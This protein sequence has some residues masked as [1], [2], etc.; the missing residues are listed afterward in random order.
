LSAARLLAT[1]LVALAVAL[2]TPAVRADDA[3]AKAPPAASKTPAPGAKTAPADAKPAP[4]KKPAAKKKPKL[5]FFG[6]R[7][8]ADVDQKSAKA[9]SDYILS[10]L[11]NAGVYRVL[12]PDDVKA[13]LSLQAQQQLLGCHDDSAC[14]AQIAGSLGADRLLEGSL[15]R[16][17]SSILVSLTLLDAT[18]SKAL[19]RPSWRIHTSGTLEPVLD[20]VPAMITKLV[21]SDPALKAARTQATKTADAGEPQAKRPPS[22]APQHLTLGLYFG[23]GGT[24]YV[25]RGTGVLGVFA[26]LRLGILDVYGSFVGNK[27]FVVYPGA[28]PLMSGRLDL[29]LHVMK[30]FY[31][32]FFGHPTDDQLYVGAGAVLG[33]G[34]GWR[35]LVGIDWMIREGNRDRWSV[36]TDLSYEIF[37]NRVIQTP[38]GAL[39]LCIGFGYSFL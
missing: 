1:G 24:T 10:E 5:A 38:G 13:V 28:D 30:P 18:N 31:V 35:A 23:G 16:I 25:V 19:A 29:R 27:Q 33:P 22:P 7:G 14:L 37:P 2:P 11:T 21:A 20:K 4:A 39:L 36:L 8:L 32:E 26:L 12:S 15:S 34:I 9:V 6:L 17:G 3:A